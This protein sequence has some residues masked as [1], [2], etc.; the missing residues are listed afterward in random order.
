MV[1]I[2]LLLSNNDLMI[3][4]FGCT[5]LWWELRQNHTNII[6]QI[7]KL[8]SKLDLPIFGLLPPAV[9][10]AQFGLTVVDV[11]YVWPA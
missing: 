9:G 1:R 2:L 5:S 3:D 8:T 6:E 10:P 7:L 11:T 4:G